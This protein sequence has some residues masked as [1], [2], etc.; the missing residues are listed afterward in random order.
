MLFILS[1]RKIY[2][3]T[4]KLIIGYDEH[5]FKQNLRDSK[6]QGSLAWGNPWGCTESDMTYL[7]GFR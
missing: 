2:S 1:F 3:Q 6:G 4:L 7:A 5:E